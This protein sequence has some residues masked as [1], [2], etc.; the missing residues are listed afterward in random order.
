MTDLRRLGAIA[1]LTFLVVAC[2]GGGNAT[3]G[4]GSS[5]AT[6]GPTQAASSE[7]PGSTATDAPGETP[8]E[9]QSDGGGGGAAD[10]CALVTAD[11]AGTI[12]GLSGVTTELT[13]GDFSYCFYRDSTGGAVGATSY[14]AHGGASTFAAWQGG[15]GAQAV[16]GIGDDAVFDPSSATLFVLKGDAI[17]GITA[18]ISSDSEADR[19]EWAKAFGQI[20]AD[21]M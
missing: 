7:Q 19:L 16:D 4:P 10:A 5:A 11:E 14:T 17:M 2:G 18:G 21:R 3:T 15:S 8:G 9:T 6:S 13:P 1:A 20:A 12:L